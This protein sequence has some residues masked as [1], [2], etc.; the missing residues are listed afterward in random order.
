MNIKVTVLN[1]HYVPLL[2]VLSGKSYYVYRH[3]MSTIVTLS[4]DNG[5]QF[6]P[7]IVHV[8]LELPFINV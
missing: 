6:N 1:G 5:L 7:A 3:C 2:F 8:D 4:F